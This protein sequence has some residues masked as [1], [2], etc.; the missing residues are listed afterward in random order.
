[1]EGRSGE[2]AIDGERGECREEGRTESDDTDEATDAA[3]SPSVLVTNPLP[4]EASVPA[5]SSAQGASGLTNAGFELAPL[6]KVTSQL[7]MFV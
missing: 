4:L 7:C 1:M 5:S 6:G 2:S 3:A